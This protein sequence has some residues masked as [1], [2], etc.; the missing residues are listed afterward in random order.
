MCDLKVG[1]KVRIID[2][3]QNKDDDGEFEILELRGPRL[4]LRTI[5][6]AHMFEGMICPVETALVKWVYKV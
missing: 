4:L 6:Y 2:S 1:D 3:M 5:T